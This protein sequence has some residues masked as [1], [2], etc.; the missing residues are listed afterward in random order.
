MSYATEYTSYQQ[1]KERGWHIREILECMKNGLPVYNRRTTYRYP[2]PEKYHRI[3][4]LKTQL[5]DLVVKT[6]EPLPEREKETIREKMK[7]VSRELRLY[8]RDAES[9]K[10][11]RWCMFPMFSDQDIDDLDSLLEDKATFKNEDLEAH[12]LI[13]QAE[14]PQ[15]EGAEIQDA[16]PQAEKSESVNSELLKKALPVYDE[17]VTLFSDITDAGSWRSFKD[18]TQEQRKSIFLEHYQVGKYTHIL[19]KDITNP[20][21]LESVPIDQPRRHHAKLLR[22]IMRRKG[23][24]KPFDYQKLYHACKNHSK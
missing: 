7:S 6:K 19:Q 1:L 13:G 15:D 11:W 5:I 8:P 9:L 3:M 20:E 24:V 12:D 10:S 4:Q 21:S 16:P 17:V 22:T 14:Q 2:C 23:F 18:G